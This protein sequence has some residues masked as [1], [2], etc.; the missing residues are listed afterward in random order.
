MLSKEIEEHR[1]REENLSSELEE[2]S[3][4]FELWEAEAS[5]FYFDLQISAVREVLLENKVHELMDVCKTLE[6]QSS[7]K[8]MEIEQIQSK[9]KF[10]ES[11]VRKLETK[12]SAYVPVVA[13][14]KENVA[15][16]EHNARLKTKL[17]E[18]SNNHVIYSY[19]SLCL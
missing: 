3:N 14:L 1:I 6:G 4:K 5:G 7:A 15:S 18:A 11:H 19:P 8:T 12:L 2:K 17:L 16:L 9:V 13:S 10:L